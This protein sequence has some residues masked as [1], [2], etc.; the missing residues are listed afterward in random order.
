MR[1]HDAVL[2]L[3]KKKRVNY[4]CE[5]SVYGYMNAVATVRGYNGSMQSTNMDKMVVGKWTSGVGRVQLL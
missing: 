1:I 4:G 3:L 5:E 2:G